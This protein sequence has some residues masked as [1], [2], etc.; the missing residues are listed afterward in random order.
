MFKS[1]AFITITFF[2]SQEIISQNTPGLKSP[3]TT[4]FEN[5][6]GNII[7]S[8]T[9]GEMV[10]VQS[11]TT[12]GILITQGLLQPVKFIK[13]SAN[14]CFSQ[15]EVKL[16]PNP[17]NGMFFLQ[18]NIFKKGELQTILFD[19][20]GRQVLQDEFPYT[21]FT[22]KQYNINKLPNGVYY[23]QLLFTETGTNQQ[24]KCIYTVEKIN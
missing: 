2:C 6:V 3:V 1:V 9:I 21:A 11:W 18:L 15:A 24:W 22:T 5:R 7:I 4:A 8:Y 10:L 14:N 19:A 20:S 23:L 12:N 16:Y 17:D 13:D